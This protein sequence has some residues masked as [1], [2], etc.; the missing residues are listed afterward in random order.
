MKIIT[1]LF[2]TLILSLAAAA[3]ETGKWTLIASPKGDFTAQ[4]PPNFLVDNE[5]DALRA[6]AFDN[7]AMMT[8]E[9]EEGSDAKSRIKMMRQ[10]LPDKEA[11]ASQFE[12]GNFSGNMFRHEK[13]KGISISIYMAS[14]KS[15]ISVFA[16]AK[17]PKNASVLNFLYSIRLN[18]QPLFKNAATDNQAAE[19]AVSLASLKT[20]PIILNMLKIRNAGKAPVKYA[21]EDAKKDE[22][23]DPNKYSRPMIT[24]RKSPASYTDRGRENGVR[25][26][27]RLKVVFRA[28]G[29]IGE[30]TVLQKLAGGLTEEAINAARKIKF[31][32]AEIDGKPVDVAK[33]V[34]YTFTIY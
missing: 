9:I 27:V 26:T 28:D 2:L 20:S 15:F 4:L 23:E 3:Q 30:I 34:E 13:D 16:R 33:V 22:E 32:P 11:R 31:V 25:G 17:D 6:Y 24:L 29:Q 5:D 14:S 21:L 8:V 10:F 12:L 19:N 7:Q 18:N 1:S